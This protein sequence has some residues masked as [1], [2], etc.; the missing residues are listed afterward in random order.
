[1]KRILYCDLPCHTV[2]IDYFCA[3]DQ[4]AFD[5]IHAFQWVCASGDPQ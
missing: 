2:P 4:A 3:K 5:A 1:M